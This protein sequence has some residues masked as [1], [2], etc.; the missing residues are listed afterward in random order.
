M[1]TYDGQFLAPPAL[2]EGTTNWM[3]SC[4]GATLGGRRWLVG[5]WQSGT[6]VAPLQAV[7]PNPADWPGGAPTPSPYTAVPIG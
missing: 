4:T 6:P 7:S 2:C 1:A 3:F 5:G